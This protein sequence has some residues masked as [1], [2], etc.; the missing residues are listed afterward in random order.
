MGIMSLYRTWHDVSPTPLYSHP[1]SCAGAHVHVRN[2][3]VHAH[4][5]NASRKVPF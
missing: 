3:H 2:V 5:S 1:F 4:Q